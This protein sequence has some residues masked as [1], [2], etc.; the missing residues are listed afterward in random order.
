MNIKKNI[1]IIYFES[2]RLKSYRGFFSKVHPTSQN[3]VD[4]Y[5]VCHR[6]DPKPKNLIRRF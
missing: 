3:H 1:E 6:M 4:D 2:F 5:L